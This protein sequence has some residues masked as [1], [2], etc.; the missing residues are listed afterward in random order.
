M[1]K[2]NKE[3]YSTSKMLVTNK[4]F[5]ILMTGRRFKPYTFLLAYLSPTLCEA[6]IP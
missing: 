3:R 2:V 1:T 4:K 6:E 5:S